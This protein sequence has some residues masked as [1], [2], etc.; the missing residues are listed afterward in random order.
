[1]QRIIVFQQRGSGEQKI[2]AVGERGHG[3]RIERVISIDEDLPE[4]I[5]DPRKYLPQT[6]D[7]DLVIN[8]MLHPDLSHELAQLCSEQGVL[9]VASGKRIPVAGLVTPPTCCG[10]ARRPELGAYAEQ[11]G[12]PELKVEV[13]EG[14][15]AR[16]EVL[17]GAPCGATW[18]AAEK[19]I[20]M[21]VNQA[22]T[23]YGLEVQML[24]NADTS[25][26]D[27]IH[28]QS[29]IHFA[30]KVHGQALQKAFRKNVS[31]GEG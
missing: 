12:A 14:R 16:V 28:G 24:C 3:L 18:E 8:Y 25:N 5:D 1:M 30:G 26:W 10:L 21:P 22:P 9:V 27:P 6:I 20:G 29:P 11:F 23:R 7:A 13:A 4:V 15:V 2:K 31:G 19:I 17:R